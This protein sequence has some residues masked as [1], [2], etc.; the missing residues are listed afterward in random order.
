[1]TVS[2]WN[3]PT[4]PGAPPGQ[5]LAFNFIEIQPYIGE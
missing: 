3:S 1:L 4:E 5:Q 2:D